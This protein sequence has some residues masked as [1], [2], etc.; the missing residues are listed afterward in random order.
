MGEERCQ[1]CGAVGNDR[2]TLLMSCFYAMEETGLPF[3]ELKVI[4]TAHKRVGSKTIEGLGIEVPVYAEEGHS[5]EIQP[6]LLRVCKG[7]RSEWMGAI[8][9]WFKTPRHPRID[10]NGNIE[11]TPEEVAERWE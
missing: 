6:Y 8:E 4:G 2:R 5:C 9:A 1:R 11:M 3:E 10:E 7:C